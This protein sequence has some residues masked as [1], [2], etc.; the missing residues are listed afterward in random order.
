MTIELGNVSN[1]PPSRPSAEPSG[2]ARGRSA[3]QAP[4]SAPAEA[5]QGRWVA[6]MTPQTTAVVYALVSEQ[7][8]VQATVPAVLSERFKSALPSGG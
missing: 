1:G 5:S 7:G 2:P 8:D 3:P 4:K 6:V